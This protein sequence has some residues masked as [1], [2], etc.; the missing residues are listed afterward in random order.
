MLKNK[1]K[2]KTWECLLQN[3]TNQLSWPNPDMNI[4][5]IEQ[6]IFDRKIRK[7]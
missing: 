6:V 7:I 5:E 2:Q 3:G 4:I 1:M